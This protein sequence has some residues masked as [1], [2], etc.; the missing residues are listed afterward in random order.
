MLI[1]PLTEEDKYLPGGHPI[2]PVKDLMVN[3]FAETSNSVNN[4]MV[5]IHWGISDL[6]RSS[7]RPWEVDDLGQLVMDPDFD[8]SSADS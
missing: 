5:D 7:V 6:D 4:L 1:E 8:M 3:S 2:L